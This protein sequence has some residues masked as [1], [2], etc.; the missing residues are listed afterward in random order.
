[1][2]PRRRFVNSSTLLISWPVVRR[3]LAI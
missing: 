3:L 2:N 1:M